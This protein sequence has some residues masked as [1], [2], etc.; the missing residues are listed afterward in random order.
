VRPLR[1]RI[2]P[3]KQTVAWE[4][5]IVQHKFPRFICICPSLQHFSPLPGHHGFQEEEAVAPTCKSRK[6]Q[7]I[8]HQLL[9]E[10]Q[11]TIS[12]QA[13]ATSQKRWPEKIA[14]EGVQSMGFIWRVSSGHPSRCSWLSP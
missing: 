1:P 4:H 8:L 13:A 3:A 9:Q 5:Q 6:S 10:L 7:H 12:I 11:T 14:T 2:A